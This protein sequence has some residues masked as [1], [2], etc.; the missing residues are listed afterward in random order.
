LIHEN[1]VMLEKSSAASLLRA[2]NIVFLQYVLLTLINFV[3]MIHSNARE[4]L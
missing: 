1:K 2:R 4:D 3:K